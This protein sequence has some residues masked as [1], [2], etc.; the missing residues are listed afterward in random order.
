MSSE[1]EYR[2]KYLPRLIDDL[3]WCRRYHLHLAKEIEVKLRELS[4][5]HNVSITIE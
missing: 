1:E 3:L 2:K 4:K 5:E